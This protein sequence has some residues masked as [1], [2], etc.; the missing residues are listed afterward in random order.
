[1]RIL[2][3]YAHPNP[4]SFCHAILRSIESELMAFGHELR[5]KDLYAEGFNPVLSA[6]ELGAL[7]DGRVPDA[8]AREQEWLRWAEGLVLVYPLWWFDRPAILKGW[9][10]K[11]LTNGF[12]FEYTAQGAR[13][14]LPQHKALIVVTV[15]G[16]RQDYR[17][18]DAEE[19]IIR[20]VSD[21]TL[22]FCGI[23]DVD[24]RLFYGVPSVSDEARGAMLDE[25]RQAA[26]EFFG[27]A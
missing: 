12:A 2:I 13:G 16:S 19:L 21:G 17:D 22:G 20:P 7:N 26:R 24:H 1:M 14:L 18:M 23:S 4:A 11:V 3:V 8:I 5:V 10:D 25:A 9:F 15:G 6:A 27:R